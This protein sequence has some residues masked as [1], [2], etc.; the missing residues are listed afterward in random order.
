MSDDSLEA[1]VAKLKMQLNLNLMQVLKN[2]LPF[3]G[4]GIDD[5]ADIYRQV[6]NRRVPVG[7]TVGTVLSGNTVKVYFEIDEGV[8][9]RLRLGE[10]LLDL[11]RTYHYE[12]YS[13]AI[14]NE[15]IGGRL[16]QLVQNIADKI[17]QDSPDELRTQYPTPLNTARG[18]VEETDSIREDDGLTHCEMIGGASPR[19]PSITELRNAY[20]QAKNHFHMAVADSINEDI[21][22][23][24]HRVHLTESHEL[25]LMDD[26]G[27]TS[28]LEIGLTL[29][30]RLNQPVIT[31]NAAG[32][33]DYD[34]FT[35]LP[36]ST[37][38]VMLYNIMM[39]AFK[40][41]IEAIDTK[42]Q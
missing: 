38:H 39:D 24:R 7:I 4:L 9:I 23:G 32:E 34:V 5:N 26:A 14:H 42:N 19:Q 8:F 10:T 37:M 20:I 33:V 25:I 18:L 6:G 35:T 16:K 13:L 3:D 29:D 22:G 17:T 27:Q 41:L 31:M 11:F 2:V 21:G 12:L 1:R 30:L 36:A 28:H 40:T 15:S